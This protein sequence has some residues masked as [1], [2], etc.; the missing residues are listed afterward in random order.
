M[1]G[2]IIKTDVKLGLIMVERIS[3]VC[4]RKD[5]KVG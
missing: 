1:E 3:K 4:G 2:R 5:V